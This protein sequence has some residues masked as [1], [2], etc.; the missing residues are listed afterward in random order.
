MSR[1]DSFRSQ[2]GEI[3]Q[4]VKEIAPLLNL[5]QLAQD[6]GA[7]RGMLTKLAGKLSVHLAMEDK[8]LY[9][10]MLANGDPRVKGTA[11]RFSDEMGGIKQV[12]EQYSKKWPTPS[13]IQG[14]PEAF[15]KETKGLFDALGKRITRENNELYPLYDGMTS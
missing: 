1:S 15:V 6:A 7:V 12:F 11:Q 9:P 13:A 4:M 5:A 10:L 3:L 2:H 14:N 8:S